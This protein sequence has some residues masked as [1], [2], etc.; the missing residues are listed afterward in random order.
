MVTSPTIKASAST[1]SSG[2]NVLSLVENTGTAGYVRFITNSRISSSG[3]WVY[4]G[5]VNKCIMSTPNL[6][7]TQLYD[8][9]Y[10]PA[11][12]GY[13]DYAGIFAYNCTTA[14]D[15][16]V[17][18]PTYSTSY[19]STSG[20]ISNGYAPGVPP[21][22]VIGATTTPGN[23]SLVINFTSPVNP[24]P[25]AYGISL[26]DGATK[27]AGGYKQQ[28]SFTINGLTNGKTYTIN[29]QPLSDD[30]LFGPITTIT[31]VPIN[32]CT[33]PTCTFLIT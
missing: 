22:A 13:V 3:T 32:P 29:I 20:N 7:I 10:V 15:C 33:T 6:Y 21:T 12:I 30:Y 31:G 24:S 8:Y 16:S 23:G 14:N 5:A 26:Y 1:W 4:A 17:A 2:M 11:A 19:A 9:V 27:L 18:C 28:T 25:F